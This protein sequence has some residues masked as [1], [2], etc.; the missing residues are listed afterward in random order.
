ME[1]IWWGAVTSP[2]SRDDT[3]QNKLSGPR[4]AHIYLGYSECNTLSHEHIPSHV[5]E[6]TRKNHLPTIPHLTTLWILQRVHGYETGNERRTV[7]SGEGDCCWRG[8]FLTN[9]RLHA[10]WRRSQDSVICQQLTI[11]Y[12][13]TTQFWSGFS[14]P[15]QKPSPCPK[16]A[17]L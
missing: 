11:T 10:L 13:F 6:E 4:F 3:T 16:N 14:S 1:E 12:N 7:L 15:L 5:F 17:F 2:G 8:C 9:E